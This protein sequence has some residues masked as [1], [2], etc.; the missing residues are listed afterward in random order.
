M[1]RIL[2]IT[3][4]GDGPSE[5]K[6]SYVLITAATPG[7]YKPKPIQTMIKV[8]FKTIVMNV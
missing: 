5:Q 2:A 7:M 1:L 8:A 3:D 4:T 6:E